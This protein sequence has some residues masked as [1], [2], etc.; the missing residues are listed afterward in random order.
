MRRCAFLTLD[1]PNGYVIDDDLAYPALA[2]LGW[3]VT[4]VPWRRTGVEWAAFDAVVILVMAS[5]RRNSPCPFVEA[6]STWAT[7]IL[8]S[9][10]KPSETMNSA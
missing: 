9:F 10:M 3:Q 2:A 7:Q 8:H 6:S 4:A 1:D 5:G